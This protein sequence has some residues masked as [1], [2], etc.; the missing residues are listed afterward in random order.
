APLRRDLDDA[1][2]GGRAVERRRRR[3][4]QDLDR[5][6]IGRV[7]VVQTRRRLTA[8]AEAE[9]G[10]RALDAHTVD[11]DQRRV[12]E[13]NAVRAADTN[14]RARPR[15]PRALEDRLARDLA[16]Q[17]LRGVRDRRELHVL[18]IHRAD[19]VANLTATLLTARGGVD[20]QRV[21][22]DRA[23]LEREV[24]DRRLADPDR[25]G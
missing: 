14:A 23:H 12:R 13:R 4:L 7:D 17:E 8:Y 15:H 22:L 20:D 18:D 10:L 3:P 24:L 11:D 21:E 16:L 1:V 6:D 9:R 2:R 5:L 19:G 25:D